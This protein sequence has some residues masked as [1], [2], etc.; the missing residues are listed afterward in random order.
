M[1][2]DGEGVTRTEPTPAEVVG[3]TGPVG[4]VATLAQLFRSARLRWRVSPQLRVSLIRWSALGLILT[5]AAGAVSATV[6]ISVLGVML[7]VAVLI[8]VISVMN[9]FDK[10]L[11]DKVLGFNAH[12]LNHFRLKVGRFAGND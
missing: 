4:P 10:E 9:G 8:I 12:Q 2:G 7:G 11:R 6:A 1:Q 3:R 5:V